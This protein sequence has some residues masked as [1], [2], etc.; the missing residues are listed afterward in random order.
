MACRPL[1]QLGPAALPAGAAR[2]R[3]AGGGQGAGAKI[4]PA[5]RRLPLVARLRLQ[6]RSIGTCRSTVAGPTAWSGVTT[7]PAV[8]Q[9]R[10]PCLFS[11]PPA[12]VHRLNEIQHACNGAIFAGSGLS[13]YIR[14]LGTAWRYAPCCPPSRRAKRRRH[15]CQEYIAWSR[16]AAGAK[17]TVQLGGGLVAHD[18]GSRPA[19]ASLYSGD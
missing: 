12:R 14:I 18:G 11:L 5:N 7:T 17:P 1:L 9:K 10:A 3:C 8:H 15:C 4:R 6:L 16:T 2:R 13:Q 19:A